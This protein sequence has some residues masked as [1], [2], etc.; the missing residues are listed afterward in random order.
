MQDK[1][2]NYNSTMCDSTQNMQILKDEIKKYEEKLKCLNESEPPYWQIFKR[3]TYEKEKASLYLK[4]DSL[5]VLV[6]S[7]YIDQMPHIFFIN[8]C[9]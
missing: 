1:I 9:N 4:L 3:N 6:Y 8:K 7:E 5:W 2:I